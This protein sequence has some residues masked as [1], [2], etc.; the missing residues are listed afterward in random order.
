MSNNK[1]PNARKRTDGAVGAQK[2][3]KIEAAA[4]AATAT[5]AA[6]PSA[7][8]AGGTDDRK[9]PVRKV[10]G[11]GKGGKGGKCASP[12]EPL[13]SMSPM[14]KRGRLLVLKWFHS[15]FAKTLVR[16][17]ALWASQWA[18]NGEP[19]D[20]SDEE[21]DKYDLE[22]DDAFCLVRETH[23]STALFEIMRHL[24]DDR[25][26]TIVEPDVSFS[27]EA[28]K[29]ASYVPGKLIPAEMD[30]GA[31]T[32]GEQSTAVETFLRDA[33]NVLTCLKKNKFRQRV[34]TRSG[35]EYSWESE[36]DTYA[37]DGDNWWRQIAKRLKEDNISPSKVQ[38]RMAKLFPIREESD[39]D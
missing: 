28:K 23:R 14:S 12:P 26:S 32:A 11:R 10:P 3:P 39:D 29:D 36:L 9:A 4:A 33:L 35:G 18:P 7:T 13:P 22:W 25:K 19:C 17:H 21:D 31:F 30:I 27:A 5:A 34:F 37:L 24:A 16:V 1:K 2:K 20:R 8:A 15:H 38:P 6:T